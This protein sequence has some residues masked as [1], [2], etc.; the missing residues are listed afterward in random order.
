M[1]DSLKISPP[2]YLVEGIET[3]WKCNKQT[4]V[5][6]LLAPNIENT[7]NEVC[8][9][10]DIES[11]PSEVLSFIQQLAPNFKLTF[12]KMAGNEYYGNACCKCGVLIGDFFLHSE[13]DGAFFPGGEEEAKSLYLVEVPIVEVVRAEAS[14]HM[15]SGDLILENAKKRT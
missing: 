3:C 4:Q 15:G 14:L 11:L 1:E 12:S 8:M 7:E 2:L 9:L 13:P 5:F 10:S 6:S